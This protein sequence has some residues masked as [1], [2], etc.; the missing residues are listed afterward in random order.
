MAPPDPFQAW[1]HGV[2]FCTMM[3]EAQTVIAL[4]VMGM[5][6][7]L[8]ASPRERHR[9]VSEKG[10]AFAEAAVAAG[11]AAALG[12]GPLDVAEAALKPIGQRTRAN[13]KRLTKPSR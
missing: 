3:A 8:P 6:G 10:P 11:R 12:K 4:R 1:R 7:V 5:W 9:M 2:A 13:V